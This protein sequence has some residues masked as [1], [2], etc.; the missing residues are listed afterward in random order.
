MPPIVHRH[1]SSRKSA[2]PV[3]D[4]QAKGMGFGKNGPAS[5]PAIAPSALGRMLD[6]FLARC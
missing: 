6:T 5:V 4:M 1:S 2:T 3:G